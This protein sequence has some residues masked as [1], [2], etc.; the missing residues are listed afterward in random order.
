MEFELGSDFCVRG[1]TKRAELNGKIGRV[2]GTFVRDSGRYPVQLG[3]ERLLLKPEN[4]AS[5]DADDSDDEL[6]EGD[7]VRHIT[8]GFGVVLGIVPGV[9]SHEDQMYEAAAPRNEE[10]TAAHEVLLDEWARGDS[11]E[12]T[13]KLRCSRSSLTTVTTEEEAAAVLAAQVAVMDASLTADG[14]GEPLK[15][16]QSR[17][18]ASQFR[19]KGERYDACAYHRCDGAGW[20]RAGDGS[21][22]CGA[23]SVSL[24]PTPAESSGVQ[25]AVL[26]LLC[27]K[28]DCVARCMVT[29]FS[30]LDSECELEVAE[31][32][33]GDDD[34][35]DAQRQWAALRDALPGLYEE[36]S[37]TVYGTLVPGT[38]VLRDGDGALVTKWGDVVLD[39]GRLLLVMRPIRPAAAPFPVWLT[40]AMVAEW[41]TR[42]D[43]YGT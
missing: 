8:H 43:L 12:P 26:R 34:H 35:A 42:E 29:E 5:A 9:W 20:Q 10:D 24:A 27:S 21:E 7:R 32:E 25:H 23:L 1:L 30:T 31:A 36:P 16:I 22:T 40:P 39:L 2:I 38:T 33:E 15:F 13:R 6:E 17:L 18:L 4:M 37:G 19:F 28:N 11:L 3:S 14:V 41:E